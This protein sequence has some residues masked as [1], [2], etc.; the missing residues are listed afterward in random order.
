MTRWMS[1]PKCSLK[2]LF[3]ESSKG[4]RRTTSVISTGSFPVLTAK[5][6]TNPIKEA[7]RLSSLWQKFGP[8]RYPLDIEALIDGAILTSSFSDTLVID[9]NHFDSLEGALVR[10][11]G[12][13]RWAILLNEKIRNTRRQRFTLAHEL[14][15]F[16]CHRELRDCFGDSEETLNDFRDGI[17]TEANIFASWLLMPANLIRKEFAHSTWNTD[18]LCEMGNRFDCSLQASALRY[19]RLSTKPIAFVVSRDGFILWACKSDSA[20][21]MVRYAF[22]DELPEGSQA[23]KNHGNDGACSS[24]QAV[25]TVWNERYPAVESWYSDRSGNGYQY[26]CIEFEVR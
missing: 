4:S 16:M 22:G 5:K 7:I 6:T 2:R 8:N 11:R 23:R 13:R 18:T 25:G 1:R 15:H 24:H 17:E 21:F 26:T 12:T 14:G 19:V 3:S 10:T 9:R 20:P